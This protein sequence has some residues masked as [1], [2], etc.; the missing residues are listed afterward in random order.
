MTFPFYQVLVTAVAFDRRAKAFVPRHL[1]PGDFVPQNVSGLSHRTVLQLWAQGATPNSRGHAIADTTFDADVGSR[2]LRR[3]LASAAKEMLTN[4]SW[5]GSRLCPRVEMA[6]LGHDSAC[7]KERQVDAITNPRGLLPALVSTLLARHRAFTQIFLLGLNDIGNISKGGGGGKAACVDADAKQSERSAGHS[8]FG[9][10]A[11]VGGVRNDAIG[12]G[13]VRLAPCSLAELARGGD[14]PLVVVC[15]F[16][17]VPRGKNLALLRR[18]SG[19]LA[20]AL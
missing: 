2:D 3:L 16:A 9:I 11:R 19:A 10:C 15:D 14:G 20:A 6:R 4:C 7:S 1:L 18:A 12:S 8:Y 13:D 17:G 5:S